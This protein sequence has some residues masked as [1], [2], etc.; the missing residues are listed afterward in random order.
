M[1]SVISIRIRSVF[2]PTPNTSLFLSFLFFLVLLW[3]AGA[4]LFNTSSYQTR[5][6]FFFASKL[7]LHETTPMYFLSFATKKK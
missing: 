3:T 2:I 1:I 7:K 4:W 6:S 5:P